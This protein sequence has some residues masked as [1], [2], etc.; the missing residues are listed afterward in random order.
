MCAAISQAHACSAA[1]PC[2][3]AIASAKLDAMSDEQP[4]LEGLA[5]DELAKRYLDLWQDQ[6]AAVAA[7]PDMA[8]TMGRYAQIWAAMGPA[9]LA[10]IWA[11]AA[12]GLKGGNLNEAG[13][14]ANVFAHGAFKD[15]FG[16]NPASAA[17]GPAPAG[18]ARDD[19]GDELAQLRRRVAELEAK[20]AAAPAPT[21]AA[22]MAQKPR[23]ARKRAGKR[24][25]KAP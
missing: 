18:A 1:S 16:Q 25:P 12:D 2:R 10:G 7:D 11:A 19:R 13:Q 8:H 14:A 5:L 6:I 4:P 15:F 23:P 17:R 24:T 21:A 3:P 20:L 9:G 22:P